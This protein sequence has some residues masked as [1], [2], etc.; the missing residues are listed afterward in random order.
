MIMVT[1]LKFF[2]QQHSDVVL[3]DM[4]L[5]GNVWTVTVSIGIMDQKIKQVQIDA[6]TGRIIGMYDFENVAIKNLPKI[7]NEI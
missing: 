5:K 4:I 6:N 1:A 3:E 2:E 7:D